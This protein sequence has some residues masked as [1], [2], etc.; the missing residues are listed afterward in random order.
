[1]ATTRFN[2][3]MMQELEQLLAELY[4]IL[5][6][7]RP[8][9]EQA[10]VRSELVRL[11]SWAESAYAGSASAERLL[12]GKGPELVEH[13]KNWVE[14]AGR[15]YMDLE[16]ESPTTAPAGEPEPQKLYET[17][18]KLEDVMKTLSHLKQ[19]AE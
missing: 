1:M 14:L 3:E 7:N 13:M 11:L 19:K 15:E 18:G 6:E 5:S 4:G 16:D 10:S 8:Q 9:L 2:Q 17:A 12:E